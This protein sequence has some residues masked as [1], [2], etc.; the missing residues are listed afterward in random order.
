[1]N[2][3]D[4]R[5]L[6][7]KSISCCHMILTKN[8]KQQINWQ[9]KERKTVAYF[10]HICWVLLVLFQETKLTHSSFCVSVVSLKSN[11]CI[12]IM[13]V[14][15]KSQR[16]CLTVLQQFVECIFFPTAVLFG[17]R[18]VFPLLFNSVVIDYWWRLPLTFRLYFRES[19]Q[20]KVSF[21]FVKYVPFVPWHFNIWSEKGTY[22]EV[23]S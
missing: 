20:R 13:N 17:H 15:F 2:L 9:K 7:G 19:R 23:D 22:S 5:V 1:M 21:P 18:S 6:T 14:S 16:T 8:D 10:F 4:I 12:H 11:L 3:N